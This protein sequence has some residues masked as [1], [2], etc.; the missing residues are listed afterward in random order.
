MGS[1]VTANLVRGWVAP[2]ILFV[3]VVGAA[4]LAV[5]WLTTQQ[6]RAVGFVPLFSDLSKRQLRSVV[7]SANEVQFSP[8]SAVVEEGKEG[9]NFYF[10]K[11]GTVVVQ[12]PG[13]G[14]TTLGPGAYFGEVSLLDGGPRTATVRAETMVTG[15]ELTRA[16]FDRL[17]AKDPS[18]GRTIMRNMSSWLREHGED[19]PD[20][21]ESEVSRSE[22]VELGRRLRAARRSEWGQGL[23]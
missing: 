14:D 20:P 7:A 9:K 11:R 12:A 3:L 5:R 10:I 8:G 18:I 2:A 15:L 23:R 1:M 6:M 21:G 19:T 16:G 4:F 13:V 17:L 22:L